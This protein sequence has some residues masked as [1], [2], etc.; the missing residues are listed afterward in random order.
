MAAL[1]HPLRKAAEAPPSISGAS[2]VR[3]RPLGTL[4]NGKA[5]QPILSENLQCS[6]VGQAHR[7][8]LTSLPDRSLKLNLRSRRPPGAWGMVEGFLLVGSRLEVL[9]EIYVGVIFKSPSVYL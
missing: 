2:Q 3:D 1:C 9:G 5:S 8:V 6:P 4:K 7:E